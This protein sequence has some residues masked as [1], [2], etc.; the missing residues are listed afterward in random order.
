M[1]VLKR[2][3][4]KNAIAKALHTE[5]GV[6]MITIHRWLVREDTSSPATRYALEAACDAVYGLTRGQLLALH[7]GDLRR[8]TEDT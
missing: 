5:T 1:P 4:S 7:Y 3:R 6:S 2:P 8:F